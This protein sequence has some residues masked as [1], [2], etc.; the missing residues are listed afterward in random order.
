MKKFLKGL[1]ITLIIVAIGIGG[2][3]GWKY[4][5]EQNKRIEELENKLE[6]STTKNKTT[7]E[8][9]SVTNNTTTNTTSNTTTTNTTN[10]AKAF[11]MDDLVVDK[12]IKLGESAKVIESTY[13]SKITKTENVREEAVPRNLLVI[14]CE[15]IGLKVDNYINDED[16]DGGMI[17]IK[18]Y[19]K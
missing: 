2:Y 4:L 8:T 11:S 13:G 10:E 3:F 1:I 5:D 9:N 17:R 12:N 16:A 18:L 14:T 19:N 15:S 7:N 6:S